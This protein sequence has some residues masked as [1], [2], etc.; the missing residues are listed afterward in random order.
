MSE[1]RRVELIREGFDAWEAGDVAGAIARYADE[2][3]VYAPPEIGN[4]GTFHGIEGFHAWTQ[5]WLE[6]W[7][8]FEQELDFIEPFG[9]THAISRVSQRGI[10]K[11]SGIEVVRDATYVY[12]VR[13]EELVY[14]A[15]FFDHESAIAHARE[16]EAQSSV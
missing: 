3:V 15:L 16:R 10:G 7:D 9:E 6:A 14:I 13:D 1:D 11:G 8:T 12:E 5:S 2:I 4:S